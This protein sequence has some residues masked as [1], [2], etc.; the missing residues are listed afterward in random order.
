MIFQRKV[1][2]LALAVFAL[3]GSA[4]SFASDPAPLSSDKYTA[5]RDSLVAGAPVYSGYYSS[6]KEDF[7]LA[8]PGYNGWMFFL[9]NYNQETFRTIT[10][11]MTKFETNTV[12]TTNT[13]VSSDL[14]FN[15]YDLF[16]SVVTSNTLG[17]SEWVSQRADYL[18]N[19][20][21]LSMS[22]ALTTAMNERSVCESDPQN[23]ANLLYTTNYSLENVYSTS[24]TVNPT[25]NSTTTSSTS[26]TTTS[27]NGNTTVTTTTTTNNTTNSTTNST[28]ET[29]T[30][31]TIDNLTVASGAN[32]GPG[33]TVDTTTTRD[34]RTTVDEVTSSETTATTTSETRTDTTT[35]TEETKR[36]RGERNWEFQVSPM[37]FF[38]WKSNRS[39][40][41]L[42]RH[43]PAVSSLLFGESGG[44]LHNRV[45]SREL[46]AFDNSMNSSSGRLIPELKVGD[47]TGPYRVELRT[48]IVGGL[49]VIL[50]AVLVNGSGI[51]P[52]VIPYVGVAP[53]AGKTTISERTI[54]SMEEAKKIK[55]LQ[56]PKSAE[57]LKSWA[58][59]DKLSYAA[60]GGV[61]FVAGVS[62][63]GLNV[64]VN[65]VINGTWDTEIRKFSDS[66][67][68]VKVSNSKLK[69]ISAFASATIVQL[70]ATKF[71]NFTESFSY[72]FN[73][74]DQ[75]GL[76]AYL[77]LLKGNARNAQT[78]AATDN[79]HVMRIETSSIR[80]AG[81]MRGL[82][83]GIAN[84]AAVG[85]AE[86]TYE[87]AELT[88]YH[89][90]QTKIDADYGIYMK[91]KNSQFFGDKTSTTFGF[92]GA[93]HRKTKGWVTETGTFGSV[94][95]AYRATEAK[96][97]E[98]QKAVDHLVYQTGLK[99]ELQ[100]K[101]SGDAQLSGNANIDFALSIDQN[102][103]DLLL[104]LAREQDAATTLSN[105]SDG[106]VKSV[107][108]NGLS[109]E[110]GRKL[111]NKLLK[112]YI[113]SGLSNASD[114]KLAMRNNLKRMARAEKKILAESKT[115]IDEMIKHLKAMIASKAK[116]DRKAY[117]LAYAQ[118]GKA[119]IKNQFTF[120]TIFNLIK[121]RGASVR[122]TIAGEHI[123]SYELYFDWKPMVREA[124]AHR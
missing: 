119:M 39:I 122:Y 29:T 124:L 106:F 84:I 26:G 74:K 30:S 93:G 35:T 110:E 2:A 34:E 91:E 50:Q 81:N 92:Y 104:N 13:N 82:S 87:S 19:N 18:R 21:G 44:M 38:S 97:S 15:S 95:W 100:V 102:A 55:A 52:N 36:V 17:A 83:F 66:H 123:K 80:T 22:E 114:P 51:L 67:V 107:M 113:T 25:T 4:S 117:V 40:F 77:Q 6:R 43:Y 12:I 90:D 59:Y 27:T 108:Q 42:D 88:D 112:Q 14:L 101:L 111:I 48:E 62:M 60:Q 68:Y 70:N 96:Q 115:A 11:T 5:W 49:G 69:T 61:L 64:G 54:K 10:E 109:S 3:L 99:N 85:S 8:R 9:A 75:D 32:G 118:F 41:S 45:A 20:F 71:Q 1:S 72:M 116:Q 7:Q 23:C 76:S 79:R 37:I 120:Q 63:P 86:G 103:T 28:T 65:H 47:R 73:L 31:G 89:P 57:E 121:G 105:I 58:M 56:V 46:M 33:G 16:N 24:T 94:G 53:M 78:L 98:I